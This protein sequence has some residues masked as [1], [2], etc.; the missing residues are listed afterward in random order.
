MAVVEDAEPVNRHRPSVEVLF[1]SCAQFAGRNAY[2]IM[3]TGMGNDGA[4][5]MKTMRDAGSYNYVQNEATCVVFG[6]PRE[7]IQAGAADEVLPLEQIAPALIA[8][9]SE[10]GTGGHHRV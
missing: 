10:S 4:A 6:M 8:K 9:M 2:G 5:A 7:A 3:L 1:L